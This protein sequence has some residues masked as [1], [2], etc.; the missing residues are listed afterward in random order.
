MVIFKSM[1]LIWGF[2]TIYNQIFK[3]NYTFRVNFKSFEVMALSDS[4]DKSLSCI[5][6]AITDHQVITLT[7]SKNL[8]NFDQN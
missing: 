5:L 1:S 7:S 4:K 2:V 3:A 6:A 8:E